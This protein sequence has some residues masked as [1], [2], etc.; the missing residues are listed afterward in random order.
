[1]AHDADEPGRP[2]DAPLTP[3]EAAERL[4]KL[5]EEA[6]RL[7]EALTKP[8]SAPAEP[9]IAPEVEEPVEDLPP[10][11]E[12]IEKAERLLQRY[13]LEHT[14]GN[15]DMASQILK[16]AQAVAPTSSVVLEVLGDDA[17]ARKQYKDALEFYR[18]AKA[19]DP[20]N[21]SAE[22]KH[23]ELVFTTQARLA[24]A[25]ISEFETVA[26]SRS[27]ALF[28]VILPG[29][30]HMVTGQVPAGIGFLVVWIG[31]VIGTI[32]IPDGVRGLVSVLTSRP[33][34]PFNAIILLPI[35]GGF[36]TWL[37][38]LTTINARSKTLATRIGTGPGPKP[39]V[40]LPY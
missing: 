28:S 33:E 18:R 32:A 8:A 14:R 34:P 23:A 26:S 22:R 11:A 6:A 3:E 40:D 9:E 2:V 16:E 20:K 37:I 7:R 15:R 35:I 13:H 21:G 36:I 4:Q 39:P 31:C 1:M 38:A 19:A 12:Q 24:S 27:A 5:E 30:G 10:T 25:G 29:L 17:A